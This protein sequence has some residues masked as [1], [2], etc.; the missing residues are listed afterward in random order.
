MC[1]DSAGDHGAT[2]VAGPPPGAWL[3]LE[4]PVTFTLDP[5]DAVTVTTLMDNVIDVQSPRQ[6]PAVRPTA[7]DVPRRD[8]ATM[9]GGDGPDALVAEH[10]F[11][12]LVTVTKGDRSRTLL[13]DTG[14]TPDGVV[15]NMRRLGVDPTSIEAV[16]CSHGHYDHTAGLAGLAD[17]LGPRNLPVVLHPHFWRRRRLA[18]PGGEPRE[19]PTTS[20]RALGEA[21]FEVVEDPRPSFLLDGSV[22][23]TGEVAR[24]TGYEPGM[25]A[26]QAWGDGRWEPDQLVLDDQ[27]LVVEVRGKGLVVVTGCGHAGVVNICRWARRLTG[28]RPVHAVVG[29]FHLNGPVFEPLLPRVLDDLAAIGPRHLVPGHCTGWR[30]HHAL[31]TRFGDAYVPCSV[32]ARLEL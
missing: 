4:P 26:Q 16:V 28:E 14:T 1:T 30:A 6:G 29:G 3:D 20:R 19:L 9:V 12:V 22:L 10:G 18:V 17:V 5:V 23:V 15:G 7:G 32:G 2:A 21:G 11:S 24:T 25:P 13:F 31:A 27:A 8:V